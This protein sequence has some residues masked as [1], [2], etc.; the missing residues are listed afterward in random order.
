MDADQVR[1]W[2]EADAAFAAWLD[3]PA[4]E[5]DAWLQQQELRPDARSALLQLIAQHGTDTDPLVPLDAAAVAAAVP[6]SGHNQLA[7]RRVGAWTLV[8]EI[9]RGGMSVVYRARRS[10][11]GFEQQ[12]AVKLLGLAALGS[13][14]AARFEQERRLLARLHHP[15]IAAF[16]DGGLA[17]D[18]TPFIAMALVDGQTLATYCRQRGLDWRGC[19]RLLIQ[20]CGAVAHAHLNL[21]VHRDLKPGNILVTEEGVPMLLDF[22]IAKLLDEEHH[23]TR[24]GLR[25]L[26]PGYAAPEQLQGEAITTATDVYAL[27]VVLRE[28][29]GADAGLPSDLRNIIA[30]ATRVE[31]E[32][33][34]PDARALAEDLE[35]LLQDQPVQ[36]T[37]DSAGYRLRAFLRRRRG[38]VLATAGVAAALVVGLGLALWQAQRATEQAAESKRQAARAQAARDFLFA[39][40]A[41]GDR[42]RSEAADPPVSTVIAR[43]IASLQDAPP[44]DPELHA[45]MAMLLGHID[46]SIGQYERAATLLDNALAQA[47]AAGDATLVAQTRVRLGML[48]NARGK[49]QEA[50]AQFDAAI[51]ASATLAPPA[52]E[53]VR[54]AALGGWTYAMSNAGRG[55]EAERVLASVLATPGRVEAAA[56]RAELL[57][58]Q[59]TLIAAPDARLAVLQQVREIHAAVGAAPIDRLGIAT[60]IAGALSR[61]G[62]HAEA[63]VEAQAAVTLG[64]RV[65]PGNTSH[66]A[67]LY[68][69]LGSI[70]SNAGRTGAADAAL[71]Q[72]EAIYRALGD[73]ESPAFASLLHNRGTLLRDLGLAEQGVALIEQSLRLAQRQF[74]ERDRRSIIALR[75]LAFTRAEAGEL[76]V[77][78]REWQQAWDVAGETSARERFDLLLIGAHI[79]QLAGRA[80]QTELRLQRAEALSAAQA[81][82][83]PDAHR[84][85]LDTLNAARWS[86][87]GRPEAAAERFAAAAARVEAGD[88]GLW[89][90]AWRNHLAYAEHL[91]RSGQQQAA[92]EQF[93]AALRLLEARGPGLQ[94]S[95]RTRLRELAAGG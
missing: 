57:F 63:V 7:G 38:L 68:N 79:A 2:R 8:E 89:S 25:A 11:D 62:R 49:P 12:A 92:R 13:Q 17:E 10:S 39:M 59:A 51:A 36:A 71:A 87:A 75:S 44:A 34:Y 94:S 61:L 18:G 32:R 78:D 43:G 55:A 20:V 72:A 77:A 85:R 30:V 24:T 5:R 16:I 1:C 41:A 76:S 84:V 69:N 74:G 35:R 26:T 3:L 22:G 86:L 80:D 23:D 64:D 54:V 28:L 82:E 21:M 48:A 6:A 88:D 52:S 9:G 56:H 46:T 95:L 4:A 66:R 40:I 60:E 37:P 67:R 65:H 15:H 91:Q 31:P 50:L 73:V 93:A 83:L 81:L 19:V 27:G 70:L 45:E 42:E 90:A 58:A 33:R 47:T 14:G 53:A 29:C